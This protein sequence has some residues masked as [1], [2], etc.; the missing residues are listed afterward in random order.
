MLPFIVGPGDAASRDG[1]VASATTITV[2]ARSSFLQQYGVLDDADW[3]YCYGTDE[4]I[5]DNVKYP[6]SVRIDF[7]GKKHGMIFFENAY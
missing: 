1:I 6:L 3:L 7:D 5:S 2:V 4:Q